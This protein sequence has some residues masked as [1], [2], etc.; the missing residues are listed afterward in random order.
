MVCSG[1]GR[2]PNLTHLV[3][4][5]L[6]KI[7]THYFDLRPAPEIPRL[8]FPCRI[9]IFGFVLICVLATAR[10]IASVDDIVDIARLRFS[11]IGFDRSVAISI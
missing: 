1:R 9:S 6:A 10:P 2:P 7:K 4:I 5:D 11:F 3:R 8:S